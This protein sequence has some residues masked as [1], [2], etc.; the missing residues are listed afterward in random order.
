MNWELIKIA[1][2]GNE[3]AL[4][5]IIHAG[6]PLSF[7]ISCGSVLFSASSNMT[8]EKTKV[9]ILLHP[10]G[11]RNFLQSKKSIQ[12]EPILSKLL[13]DLLNKSVDPNK[14]SKDFEKW[15]FKLER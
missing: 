4:N 10:I 7:Y 9:K 12:E 11:L 5:H 15:Y 1:F 13:S 8:N 14:S 6:H 2:L 3:V